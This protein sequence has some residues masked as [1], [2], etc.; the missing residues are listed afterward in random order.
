MIKVLQNRTNNL[1]LLLTQRA[2]YTRAKKIVTLNFI[3]SVVFPII[4]SFFTENMIVRNLSYL[5]SAVFV[6]INYF[7]I[8]KI[9]NYKNIAAEVQLRFDMNIFQLNWNTNI[10]GREKTNIELVNKVQLKSAEKQLVPLKDWYSLKNCNESNRYEIIKFCQKQ[11]MV[12]EFGL[13]SSL[14]RAV[15]FLF[16]GVILLIIILTVISTAKI[17]RLCSLLATFVPFFN[18]LKSVEMNLLADKKRNKELKNLVS[19]ES[20]QEL[21]LIIENKLTTYRKE[22]GLIPDWFYKIYKLI[23]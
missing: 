13:R 2:L 1:N 5:Y 23:N 6:L 8:I 3:L 16:I 12:W 14:K 22:C 9:S 11:N 17:T 21:I 15:N 4:F 18:W 20:N 7:L 10:L 19:R